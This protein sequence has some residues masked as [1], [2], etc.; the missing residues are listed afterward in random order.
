MGTE[1]AAAIAA[2]SAVVAGLAG[3]V[4]LGRWR[5]TDEVPAMWIGA[6]LLVYSSAALAVPGVALLVSPTA[7]SSP[8]GP[9]LLRPVA[10]PVVMALFA[11]AV[12][13]RGA[14]GRSRLVPSGSA[15]VGVGLL[16]VA[17]VAWSPTVRT[18]LGPSLVSAPPKGLASFG[19]LV[20]AGAWWAL[21]AALARQP[22]RSGDAGW[23]LTTMLAA[24]GASRLCLGVAAGASSA[25]AASQTFRVVAV[26]AALG[27][28]LRGLQSLV[29]SLRR[30]LD[31]ARDELR[32][33][34]ARLE[35]A[36][37]EEGDRRHQL[38][39]GLA[40][41]GG[42]AWLLEHYERDLGEPTRT[43]LIGGVTG[44]VRRLQQLLDD[45]NTLG[46]R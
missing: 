46:G 28:T 8:R 20:V 9:V 3:L 29:I 33:E 18:I 35:E 14:G 6:G 19:Q 38:R 32:G 34:Q 44:E 40:A 31:L 4:Q 25:V 42:T 41:I 30:E 13:V 17:A 23:W 16:T 39:S 15:C 12:G 22:R 24:L 27:G 26:V 5:L 11:A 43:Q 45:S 10:V 21:A 37:A 2:A 36:E 7:A 1:A